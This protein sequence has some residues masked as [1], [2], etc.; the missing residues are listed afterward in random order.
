MKNILVLIHDDA[1][2]EARFQAGL[3][4]TRTLSGHLTCLDIAET[5]PLIA[6]FEGASAAATVLADTQVRQSGNREALERQLQNEGVSWDWIDTVGG[7]SACLKRAAD[8]TDL[9]VVNR[10]LDSN[11]APDMRGVAGDILVAAS[12]PIVAVLGELRSFDASGKAL[13]AW[14][15]S[16]A[17]SAA[18]RAATPLLAHASEV[19]IIQIIGEPIPETAQEAAAYLSRHGIHPLLRQV[20][21]EAQTPVASLLS[22]CHSGDYAYAVMGGFGHHRYAEA[23]FGGVTREMLTSSPIPL[24]LAH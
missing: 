19:E 3:D 12:K 6:D 23:M 15:S 4:L 20:A 21:H 9:I 17:A 5:P 16:P 1:G 24:F 8:L 11:W 2:Q 18:L 14:D 22:I 7:F 10:K 13:V